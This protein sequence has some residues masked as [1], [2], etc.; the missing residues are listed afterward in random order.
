MLSKRVGDD[1]NLTP[2]AEPQ[3]LRGAS[4]LDRRARALVPEEDHPEPAPRA[5]DQ[6]ARQWQ[7]DARSVAREP[8]GIDRPAVAH[9]REPFQE[10]V[11][12]RTRGAAGRIG[13][14]ADAAGVALAAQV[15]DQRLH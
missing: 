11:D 14:E 4:L 13:E 10:A 1:R 15:V 3:S 5:G 6:S 8:V 2:A 9:A 12:D 7:Q